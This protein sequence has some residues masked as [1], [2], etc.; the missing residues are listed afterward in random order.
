MGATSAPT[1]QRT[2]RLLDYDPALA[3]SLRPERR[4]EAR[5]TAQ[6][7][8]VEVGRGACS[9]ADL[10]GGRGAAY[11]VLLL[12]GLA[13][14]T[15]VLDDVASAQL[16]GRGDLVRAAVDDGGDALVPTA[17]RWTVIEPLAVALLD[18]RFLLTVRRWPEIV[19]ALFERLAAQEQRRQVHR[20]L[21]SLPRVEDRVHAL[22]WLL[23][24]RW[25]RVTSQGVVVQL[26]L[27]HELLGQLVGAKR[28]TVSLA[29]RA[30]EERGSVHRRPDGGWLLEQAWTREPAA[31]VRDAADGVRLLADEAPR[32]PEISIAAALPRPHLDDVLDRIERMRGVHE[33]ARAT[34]AD[35]LARSVATRRRSDA[36]RG[37]GDR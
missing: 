27:T 34:V 8:L 25:G 32:G 6:A 28:P 16:L 29:L 23:A 12:D 7:P 5:A 14:R 18:E 37:D 30:L 13:T 31:D 20:A 22:L 11:G 26:R 21:L 10:S 35:T 2:I 4:A 17:T 36:L 15:L 9:A 19:A 24:E 3:A 1:G 33:R